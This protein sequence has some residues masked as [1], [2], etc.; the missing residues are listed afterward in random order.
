MSIL[1]FF[2]SLCQRRRMRL[3]PHNKRLVNYNGMFIEDPAKQFGER[4]VTPFGFRHQAQLTY[5]RGV[6]GD[7]SE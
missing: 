4:L 2:G 6:T 3:T 1:E 5:T 7:Q